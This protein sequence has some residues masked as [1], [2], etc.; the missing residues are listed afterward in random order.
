M[1]KLIVSVEVREVSTY[2][3]GTVIVEREFSVIASGLLDLQTLA[4]AT[5]DF[6]QALPGAVVE[7]AIVKVEEDAARFA[8]QQKA[9]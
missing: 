9:E 7:D 8:A 5:Q 4:L 2:G 6:A 3:S 1:Y